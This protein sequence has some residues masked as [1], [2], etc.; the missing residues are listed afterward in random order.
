VSENINV[1]LPEH[2]SSPEISINLQKAIVNDS[3]SFSLSAIKAKRIFILMH[4]TLG[5]Y[6]LLKS[7]IN[8]S[9]KK[10]NLPLRSLPK[11]L[12]TL[13][14]VDES[15]RPLIER[16]FFAHHDKQD[17]FAKVQMEKTVYSKG[18]SIRIKLKLSDK[19]GKP[20]EGILSMS[21]VQNN[22]VSS[23]TADIENYFYLNRTL[24][25]LPLSPSGNGL[26]DRDYLEDILLI[27]GW[28]RYN[29]DI[30]NTINQDTTFIKGDLT[31]KGA[32]F[33]GKTPLKK[34]LNLVSLGGI[35]PSIITTKPDG[36]FSLN[37]EE[38][39]VEKNGNIVLRTSANKGNYDIKIYD[40]S[41]LVSDS[42]ID[43]MK[44][45]SLESLN[46]DQESSIVKNLKNVILLDNVQITSRRRNI[47]PTPA[48]KGANACGDFVDSYDNYAILNYEG[49][50]MEYRRKPI[51][52]R[53]YFK[54]TDL[55][56]SYFRVDRVFYTKCLAEDDQKET[57]FKGINSGKEYYM[58][59]DNESGHHSTLY[60]QSGIVV[61]STGE[62]AISFKAGDVD[63]KFSITVQGLST[64]GLVNAKENIQIK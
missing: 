4:N 33:R 62:I 49:T 21:V 1:N 47:L 28:R 41:I 37:F 46:N 31:V 59:F 6:V 36:T 52:N 42:L 40:P 2:L 50:P 44:P 51:P 58:S 56:G 11:G 23:G 14:I 60:W 35:K 61:D 27:K 13:T 20:A 12:T 19:A 48:E 34:P 25:D 53:S 9:F 16:L 45:A 54:R 63:D 8:S 32:V 5:D 17:V 15:G 43:K 29:H 24:D 64:M 18:D 10:F 26:L 7:Q 30:L 55:Q 39:L 22:R 3:L 57:S 38:Q